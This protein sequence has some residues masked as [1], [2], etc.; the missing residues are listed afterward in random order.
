VETAGVRRK[1]Y[2]KT[3]RGTVKTK[4]VAVLTFSGSLCGGKD[5]DLNKA[6][7]LLILRKAVAAQYKRHAGMV[8]AVPW[9]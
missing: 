2:L 8:S 7:L 6:T 5:E 9:L 3:K 4:C 1:G